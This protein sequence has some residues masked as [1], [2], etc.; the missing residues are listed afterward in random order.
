MIALQPFDNPFDIDFKELLGKLIR[1]SNILRA[2]E[3]D[4]RAILFCF[5]KNITFY[6]RKTLKSLSF[7]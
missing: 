5:E 7:T 3:V 6:T 4:Q 2:R 1:L